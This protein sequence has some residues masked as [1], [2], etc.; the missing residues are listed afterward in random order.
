VIGTE[1]GETDKIA[2]RTGR[3]FM[4]GIS[5]KKIIFLKPGEKPQ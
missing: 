5:R 2:G 1:K 4:G 3:F